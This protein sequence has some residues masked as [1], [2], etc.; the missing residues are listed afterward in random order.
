MPA[1][2]QDQ[3]L[4]AAFVEEGAFSIS[5]F[6]KRKHH[7]YRE[8][9]AP[10]LE[11]P[12]ADTHAHLQMLR[13]PG[14]ELARCA[15]HNV[16]FVC[17]MCDPA[18][19]LGEGEAGAEGALQPGYDGSQ[20]TF[21]RLEQWASDACTEL[22]GAGLGEY[23]PRIPQLRIA[24]GVHP[25]NARLWDTRMER[26]M[27]R[28]LADPRVCALGEVGLDYH[29]DLSPRAAQRGVFRRQIQLAK[30]AGL[31]L[32]LH[33]REAHEEGL[34]ILEEEGFPKA[35][36]LLHCF[37]LDEQALEPWAQRGCF[38]AYGGP[39]TFKKADEVRAAAAKVPHSCLLT[40][41]DSPYMT[42]EPMRGVDCGPAHVV[43]TAQ[44]LLEVLG[45]ETTQQRERLLAQVYSNALG[46]LNR[47]PTEWQ[48]DAFARLQ[49]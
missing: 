14:A 10:V 41:T 21:Q 28:H 38:I 49:G 11:G 37:N 36:V 23:A 2:T 25:H 42:P 26:L 29:Y 35:G 4:N 8:V 30:L 47:K 32:I 3:S 31:P 12:V 20:P 9:A 15:Y 24:V 43:F 22:Q 33:M 34:A 13:N 6:Q 44:K 19:G 48:R 17:A 16:R 27:L 39:L 1:E 18:D 45:C 5:F 46:L 7:K 40:E